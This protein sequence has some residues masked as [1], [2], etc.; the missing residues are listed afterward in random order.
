VDFDRLVSRLVAERRPSWLVYRS[1]PG[2]SP[3]GHLDQCRDAWNLWPDDDGTWWIVR[4][5]GGERTEERF[6]TEAEACTV[7]Y[8]R[9]AATGENG[10]RAVDLAELPE[11][12]QRLVRLAGQ[13]VEVQRPGDLV[14]SGSS[15]GIRVVETADG[16]R[17]DRM[18]LRPPTVGE[19][20]FVGLSKDEVARVVMIDA[21]GNI[22][23]RAGLPR[24]GFPG[25]EREL[26]ATALE[27]L[28]D[29]SPER[30]EQAVLG[31]PEGVLELVGEPVAL[32]LLTDALVA[33]AEVTGYEIVPDGGPD[34]IVLRNAGSPSFALHRR[35]DGYQLEWRGEKSNTWEPRGIVATLPEARLALAALLQPGFL[36]GVGLTER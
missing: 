28:A 11:A 24:W 3:A 33:L 16:D 29:V 15:M 5:W 4:G 17:I 34:S 22:P 30:L 23:R 7:L 25:H 9:V 20:W 21:A 31:D 2:R 18:S 35:P 36:R 6:A 27:R 26:A 13:A 12:A 8:D 32:E 1:A 14:V 19:T 10:V